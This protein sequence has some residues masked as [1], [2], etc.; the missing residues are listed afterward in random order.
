MPIYETRT[1]MA[2]TYCSETQGKTV[3]SYVTYVF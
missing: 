1:F 2:V 3:D